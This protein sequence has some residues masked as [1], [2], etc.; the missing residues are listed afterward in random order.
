MSGRSSAFAEDRTATGGISP[1]I[2]VY[3]LVISFA[4]SIE[5]DSFMKMFCIAAEALSN[6]SVNSPIS[7]LASSIIFC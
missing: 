3:A 1:S 6:E 2:A 7:G 4:I 5:I